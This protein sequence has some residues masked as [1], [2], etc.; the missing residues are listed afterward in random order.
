MQRETKES[1]KGVLLSHYDGSAEVTENIGKNEW[2]HPNK[3][4]EMFLKLQRA[5]VHYRIYHKLT[6]CQE[7]DGHYPNIYP[8]KPQTFTS[9]N[10]LF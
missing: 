4:D 9:Q 1:H 3:V 2:K 5:C 6:N 8:S 7:K 10:N